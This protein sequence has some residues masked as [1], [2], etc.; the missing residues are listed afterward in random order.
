MFFSASKPVAY[1][2]DRSLMEMMVV[3]DAGISTRGLR[4]KAAGALL[5]VAATGE[6][7]L[8]VVGQRPGALSR[9]LA[10]G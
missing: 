6:P 10:A 5:L 3:M 9:A 7:L 4:F 2:F 8:E 1:V